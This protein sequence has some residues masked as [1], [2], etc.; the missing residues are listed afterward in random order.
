MRIAILGSGGVGGYFGGRLAAAGADVSFV[1]R[2]AHLAGAP[3]EGAA[4]PE[5]A[6]GRARRRGNSHRR[7]G[8][9][10][11]R[12]R[13]VL[14]GEAVR[15]RIGRASAPPLV[16]SNTIVVPFQNGVDSVSTLTRAIG[17]A[18]VAGGTCYL[19]AVIAEP[20][21]IRHTAMNRLIFGDLA[22]S[23][24]KRPQLRRPAR[25]LPRRRLR[26]DAQRPTFRWTSGRSSSA[27]PS[28]AA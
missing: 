16:G 23:A 3:A 2:G 25:R 9:H 1:A 14:H 7:S 10:R 15:H 19:A 28:S 26:R 8:V 20:G 6:R 12:R 27:S 13:R 24:D 18:H 4:H 21:V 11:R 5:S 22:G 17:P